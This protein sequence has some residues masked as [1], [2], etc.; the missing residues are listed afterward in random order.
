MLKRSDF[1]YSI[2]RQDRQSKRT[3]EV[4]AIALKLMITLETK[5]FALQK[6]G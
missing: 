6:S 5:E 1:S 2:A 3:N 4:I